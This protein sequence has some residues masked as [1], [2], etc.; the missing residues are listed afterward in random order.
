MPKYMPKGCK[1]ASKKRYV[2]NG[3]TNYSDCI[4]VCTNP[5]CGTADNLTL[6]APVVYDEIGINLAAKFPL[7]ELFLRPDFLLV[8]PSRF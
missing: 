4:D 1:C 2:S 6:L 7:Q 8:L 3:I 5:I